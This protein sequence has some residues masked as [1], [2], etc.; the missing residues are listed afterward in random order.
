MEGRWWSCTGAAEV[1]FRRFDLFD[2][3]YNYLGFDR[4]VVG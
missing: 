1:G 2:V 3:L 4:K